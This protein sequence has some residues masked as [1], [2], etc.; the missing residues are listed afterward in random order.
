MRSF[1]VYDL[2]VTASDQTQYGYVVYTKSD[3]PLGVGIKKSEVPVS[4]TEAPGQQGGSY[5]VRDQEQPAFVIS[6]W[7]RGAGQ[8]SYETEG[9]LTARFHSSTA[10]DTGNKGELRLAHS[11]TLTEAV[12]WDGIV[13]AALGKMWQTS[14]PTAVADAEASVKYWDGSAWQAL[15]YGEASPAD[16]DPANAVSCLATDGEY[17]Y[18]GLGS[19]GIYRVKDSDADGSFTDESA[20]QWDAETDIVK[21]CYSGGYLYGAKNTAVGYFT[22]VPAWDQISP[23]ALA[24]ALTTFGLEPADKWAY[25]GTTSG[26]LTRVS[27]VQWDGTNEWFEDVCDFPTGFV[28]TCMAN[29][30]GN[31][32]IGGYYECATSYVG[33]G[34][35]YLIADGIPTLLTTIGDN[36]DYATD[37]LSIDNDNRVWS[38][39]PHGKDLYILTTRRV[40]RW[41]LDDGGWVHVMDVPQGTSSSA[42]WLSTNDLDYT[43]AALPDAGTWTASGTGTVSNAD[44]MTRIITAAGNA[45]VY[46]ATPTDYVTCAAVQA[47]DTVTMS[48][49]TGSY[50]YT[51]H[52]DTTTVPTAFSISGDNTADAVELAKCVNDQTATHGVT[53]VAATGV[54]SLTHTAATTCTV[55]SSNATRLAVINNSLNNTS[56][57]TMQVVV[58]GLSGSAGEFGFDDGAY[59]CRARVWQEWRSARG[60]KSTGRISVWNVALG[61]YIDSAWDYSSGD[62]LTSVTTASLTLRLTC[63][64]SVAKLY[65]DDDLSAK[66]TG[67]AASG[68]TNSIF[69][70]GGWSGSPEAGDIKYDSVYTSK[71]GAYPPG[72]EY[73]PS[74][75]G[76]IA[77]LKNRIYVGIHEIGY[78]AGNTGYVTSGKLRLSTSASKCGSLEKVYHSIIIDHEPL[79]TLETITCD[80][81]IDG[82]LQGGPPGVTT[83]NRTVFSVEQVGHNISPVITLG[84]TNTGTTPVVR[85]ITV[86]FDFQKYQ[87]HSFILDCRKGA[88]GGSW[89]YD[90]EEAIAHLFTVAAEGG[91]FETRFA[92]AF[93]GAVEQCDLVQAQRNERG[94][95]EGIVQLAVRELE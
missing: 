28:G 86:T 79:R 93:N 67:L 23:V 58:D 83:G 20:T 63:I 46:T 62:Y 59:V 29:Y 91:V 65:V 39:T 6:D 82:E 26:G 74:T 19:E 54:V 75:I 94:T 42:T 92:G 51:A 80:W 15:P 72:S 55:V 77:L 85:G 84:T 68:G 61:E 88:E 33:Q 70:G 64:G 38:M 52:A 25:W 7:S 53:A 44:G 16:D 66:V 47:N 8:K 89:A 14:V 22:A 10:I 1:P 41:D 35:I 12:A 69:F 43:A 76:S 21:L 30:L 49:A 71:V 13:L 37:P 36:P 31:I 78:V 57:T 32:Y 95:L 50:V 9:S 87:L 17:L 45:K 24:P 27:R 2:L 34:A 40:L 90:P 56:G 73:L 3:S 11:G 60:A 81:Y 48:N 18:I 4:V 5:S